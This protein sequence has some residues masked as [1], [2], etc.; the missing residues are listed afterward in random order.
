MLGIGDPRAPALDTL[1]AASCHPCPSGRCQS[2]RAG[3]WAGSS[4]PPATFEGPGGK[5]LGPTLPLPSALTSARPSAH[6]TAVGTGLLGTNPKARSDPEGPF[7]RS[8]APQSWGLGTPEPQH[9]THPAARPPPGPIRAP[10][11]I[12]SRRTGRPS[13][14]PVNSKD[15]APKPWGPCST[16]PAPSP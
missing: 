13:E 7:L 1:P 4:K 2:F 16:S 8:L 3:E 14:P 9:Q 12:Q 6:R 10:P 15:P 5:T 11:I